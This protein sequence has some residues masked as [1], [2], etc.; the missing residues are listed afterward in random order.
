MYGHGQIFFLRQPIAKIAFEYLRFNDKCLVYVLIF[1]RFYTEEIVGIAPGNILAPYDDFLYEMRWDKRHACR[2]GEYHIA[3]KYCG[4]SNAYGGIDGGHHHF[5]N[6][7]WIGTANPKVETFYF[8]QALY[9]ANG[10]IK[11][12]AALAGFVHGIAQIVAN[13]PAVDDFSIAVGNV[14]VT[15]LQFNIGA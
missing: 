15:L 6:G 4:A 1:A 5:V 13:E 7:G 8:G 14:Y 10:S 2:F 12:D 3:G 9:V 11:N